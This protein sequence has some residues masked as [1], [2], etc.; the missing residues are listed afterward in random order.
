MTSNASASINISE[1]TTELNITGGER[2]TKNIT[3]ENTGSGSAA[4]SFETTVAPDGDG[5]N[6]IYSV[7]SPFTINGKQSLEITMFINTSINL[8]G[9]IYNITIKYR[10][11]TPKKT[12]HYHWSA[13]AMITPVNQTNET[14]PLILQP[15]EENN[16]NETV[17]TPPPI[18]ESRFEWCWLIIPIVIIASIITLLALKNIK[19][20]ETPGHEYPAYEKGKQK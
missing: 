7:G 4:I 17:P 13:E 3:I 19:R 2:I 11:A 5:I 16:T 6:I 9:G 8:M 20:Q 18:I 1:L 14:T 15:A 12:V 10:D